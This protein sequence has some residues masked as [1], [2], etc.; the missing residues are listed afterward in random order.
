MHSNEKPT[1]PSTIRSAGSARSRAPA[2]AALLLET[3]HGS[4]TIRPGGAY[5]TARGSDF[6]WPNRFFA[7]LALPT[8]HARSSFDS[9]IVMVPRP[10]LGRRPARLFWRARLSSFVPV[11]LLECFFPLVIFF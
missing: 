6:A 8:A 7:R 3:G 5:Q 11:F 2:L 10:N 1:H 4:A 9:A